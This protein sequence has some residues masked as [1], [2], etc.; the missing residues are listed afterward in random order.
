MHE[1]SALSRRFWGDHEASA[2]GQHR[3][4]S[5]K[6][7]RGSIWREAV[8]RDPPNLGR[9][10]ATT[11]AI[12]RGRVRCLLL[13]EC[14]HELRG[15]TRLD[16]VLSSAPTA[17]AAT[18]RSTLRDCCFC[19]GGTVALAAAFAWK[20][21]RRSACRRRARR[22]CFRPEG[23]AGSD[24]ATRSQSTRRESSARYTTRPADTTV[25]VD[26]RSWLH[27]LVPRCLGGAADY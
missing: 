6:P 18:Y 1:P 16:S 27:R 17:C 26:F 14:G 9:S 10:F 4:P 7:A 13:A 5:L 2:S 15:G 22:L 3:H 21:R 11:A 12:S 23:G 25:A 8:T 19:L 20:R 24:P